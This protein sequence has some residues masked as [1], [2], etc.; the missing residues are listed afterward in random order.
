MKFNIL[1]T[2]TLVLISLVSIKSA[3]ADLPADWLEQ[4]GRLI[5]A[6]STM[7]TSLDA[8]TTFYTDKTNSI[9][10]AYSIFDA[11]DI[12]RDDA[13]ACIKAK[14]AT[15]RTSLAKCGT[16]TAAYTA[17]ANEQISLLTVDLSALKTKSAADIAALQAQKAALQAQI[18]A[19]NAEITEDTGA[20][21]AQAKILLDSL[22]AT[23]QSFDNSIAKR[24]DFIAEID[25]LI[26]TFDLDLA[27]DNA[28][29]TS[30][31]AEICK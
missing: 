20:S 6:T 16:D 11:V 5:A 26:S 9:K 23:M 2:G 13:L 1:R 12:I 19:L 4:M 17:S 10:E 25:K 8:T 18:D 21:E 3:Q 28:K 31:K 14:F 24:N 29:I 27:D 15:L 30:A 7:N 22:T